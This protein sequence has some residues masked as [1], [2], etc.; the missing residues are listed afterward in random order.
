MAAQRFQQQ[1]LLKNPVW[2]F[3]LFILF[4]F[5]GAVVAQERQSPNSD[6]SLT[7]FFVKF[8]DNFLRLFIPENIVFFAVGSATIASDWASPKSQSSLADDLWQLNRQL[9]VDFGSLNNKNWDKRLGAVGNWFLGAFTDNL[10]LEKLGRN[11]YQ[12]LVKCANSSRLLT[13]LRKDTPCSV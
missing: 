7:C 5:I 3:F 9:V 11:P 2:L 10:R 13:Y 1:H 6:A 4:P 8:A 12:A